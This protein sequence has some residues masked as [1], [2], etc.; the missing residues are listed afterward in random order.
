MPICIDT[1]KSNTTACD[2]CG[3]AIRKGSIK[4]GGQRYLSRVWWNHIH[5][6]SKYD[7]GKK[8][9]G[10]GNTVTN[11]HGYGALSK[12]EQKRIRNSFDEYWRKHA[13]L[14]L[15][16]EDLDKLK[17]KQLKKELEKRGLNIS[18]SKITLQQRLRDWIN[19]VSY[20]KFAQEKN[21]PL[22]VGYCKEIEN[23]NDLNIPM[24]L[25]QIVLNYYPLLLD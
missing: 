22:I 24:Y 25:Q 14:K 10:A 21:K 12:K 11:L 6:F 1:A 18:G 7:Q 15:N 8:Y 13:N 3:Q 23:A 9:I 2:Y 17:C 20:I 4:I 5:C 19:N 16:L